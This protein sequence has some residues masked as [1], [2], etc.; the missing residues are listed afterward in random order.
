MYVVKN[1]GAMVIGVSDGLQA[2]DHELKS[3]LE[4]SKNPSSKQKSTKTKDSHQF[5]IVA[6]DT[7]VF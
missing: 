4:E 2:G 6:S 7:T 5:Q 3:A 1:T